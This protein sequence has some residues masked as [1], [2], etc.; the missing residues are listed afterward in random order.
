MVIK[1]TQQQYFKNK[2][3]SIND[4]KLWYSPSFKNK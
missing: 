4:K 2:H 1:S 3:Q